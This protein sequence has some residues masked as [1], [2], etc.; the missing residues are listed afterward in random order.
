MGTDSELTTP[1]AGDEALLAHA[2]RWAEHDP[3]PATAAEVRGWID[4]GDT[5]ALAA[6]FAGPLA[7]GT[8]G[9]RAAV[10]A[11]E[12]RMNRAVVIRTTYGLM[13]WLRRTVA[14]PVVVVGCDARHGSAQFQ[15]DVAKVVAAGGG[16]ALVLPAENPTPLTAFTVRHAGADAGV[17]VTASHNPPADNGYKV[18]LGG[19]VVTGDGQGSQLIS[20]ADKEIAGEIAAAP[21][22]DEILAAA[23]DGR[24]A[25]GD[26]SAHAAGETTHANA[27]G[28]IRD[29]DTRAE[30]IGRALQLT[31]PVTDL[32]I[33]LTAMHGVGA[34]IG[35]ELLNRA[36]FTVSLVPE[37]AEPDPDFPTVEFPNPEEPGALDLGKTHAEKIGADVLIAYDPDADRCAVAVPGDSGWRQ[38]TGDE[39]GAL[40]GDYLARR[41]AAGA[42]NDAADAKGT[43]ANSIVSSRL[44]GRIAEHYGYGHEETLTG[45]KWISRV[46]G[47]VF[48]YEE[49]IG[50]CPDPDAVHD[51]DGIS[52]S[53]VLASLAAELKAEGKTLVDRLAE[54]HAMVGPLT[55]R[56]LT[57]RVADTSLIGKA[58]EKVATEP[59]TQFAGSPVA[60]TKEFS[61]GF[62]FFTEAD[63]RVVVRPSGTEPKLKCYLESPDPERL[64]PISEGLRAYFGL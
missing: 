6:A 3:D 2:R 53:V 4:S 7:F 48:G 23:S 1:A 39:T 32:T 54:I 57:F 15:K 63:D 45:F 50:F 51:K 62:I 35:E 61:Q 29:V 42:E 43:F 38:L 40:L 11:G 27:A 37:Q 33:A 64:A 46:P 55:T 30:Y 28:E 58:M 31:G 59:P 10:G 9:L 44:L 8:A 49:A 14:D 26:H 34:A 16:T 24:S 19:R 13:R 41:A 60:E 12:S 52:T 22:A 17:M 5:E 20:L 21:A 18:Y 47:L 36:G 25:D 56:P